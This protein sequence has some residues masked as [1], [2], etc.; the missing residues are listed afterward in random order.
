M[1]EL[2][3]RIISKGYVEGEIIISNS[4]ISF[5][6]G[7]SEEGIVTDKEN[8]LYGKSI[9][10]KIFVFPTGK[11]STVG[12]YVIYGLAKKGL[13]KGIVNQD[14]E[15]IV[16]TGAILGKIPLVDHVDISKLKNG[17]KIIVDGNNGI[18]KVEN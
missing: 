6:G 18:I 12:S 3:G 13:L 8:E 2:K 17:D 15:P 5:L 10:N 9:A 11:G 1:E 16:A 7:V 14:C 4:P